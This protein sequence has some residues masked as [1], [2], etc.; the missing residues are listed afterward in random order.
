MHEE[1]PVQIVV[2]AAGQGTRM[3]SQLPKVLHRIAGQP[4]LQHVLNSARAL[5]PS[6][7]HVVYGH[8]GEQVRAAIADPAIHW[9]L[10]D[11]QLG[12]GHAVQMAAPHCAPDGRVLVLYGDVPLLRP[13]TLRA[14]LDAVPAGSL[15]LMT[16]V[17]AEPSG[18]GRIVR[19]AQDS[20]ERIVEEKDA[21]AEIRAIRE[22]NT[23]IM[24]LPAARLGDWLARLENDNAQGEYYLTDVVALARREGL[25]IAAYMV[26]D[27]LEVAGVNNK[28]QLAELEREYQ[29]RRAQALMLDGVLI[30][31]PARVDIRGEVEIAPDVRLEPNVI[32]EGRVRIGAGSVIG[33]GV[34][35]RDVEIGENVQVLPYSVVEEARIGDGARVGPFARV[36][37]G[38]ALDSGVHVG[39][40]VEVKA[41]R[42]GQGSKANHLSYIGDAEIGAGVNIG[43]GTITCNYD[44]ANKHKTIIEDDAFIGSDTQL[45]APVRV[46]RGATIGAGSTITREAPA[47]ELTLSRVPQR[48]RTG[49]QRPKKKALG[50]N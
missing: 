22:V 17:L 3:R 42:I 29:R 13:E 32:L 18:Y 6:A 36:R 15:G 24:V 19:D 10:Q 11:R 2:L 25:G 34:L 4:L 1:S 41:S 20:V 39:N 45:V 38:T 40:F 23:G 14:F 28:A 50:D 12:T 30:A 7:I 48:T 47:G 33:M 8:G 16:V 46:G 31:D 5:Q 43:A 26:A 35:L 37:P 49:W 27:P 44:G 21:D 9:V